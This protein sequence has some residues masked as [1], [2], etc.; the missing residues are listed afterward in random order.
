MEQKLTIL[1][2]FNAMTKF[3]DNYY[4]K[5]LS[6]DLGSLL[7][8]MSFLEN[9]CTA[10]PATWHDWTNTIGTVDCVT[11]EQA[12]NAMQKFLDDYCQRTSSADIQKLLN[13]LKED[14]NFWKF[15]VK[16][17]NR[18]LQEPINTKYFI[19]LKS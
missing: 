1:Q 18:I 3:L 12:F 16:C 19:K 13:F 4:N 11:I 10:D 5:T 14:P 6:D 7:G 17:V 2:A 15:W 9:G 8:D